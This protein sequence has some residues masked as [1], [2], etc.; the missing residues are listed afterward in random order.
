L[1]GGNIH[2]GNPEVSPAPPAVKRRPA[3]LPGEPAGKRT[4]VKTG[5]A[6]EAVVLRLLTE[7][8]QT[9]A[10]AESCTGGCLAHRITNVPGASAVL[11]GG[12]VAYSNAAKKKFLGVRAQTLAAHGAVSEAVAREMA[13]GARN[14]FGTDFALGVTGIAGPAGGT[15]RKPVGTVF[16]ALAGAGGTIVERKLNAYKRMKFKQVTTRQALALLHL[17]L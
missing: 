11:L 13:E 10:L 7:R 15:K 12:V 1:R 16:I 2:C 14:R 6:P 5:G 3:A 17:Y 9:L 8:R 4:G